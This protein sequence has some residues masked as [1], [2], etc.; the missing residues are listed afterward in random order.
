[1]ISSFIYILGRSRVSNFNQVSPSV[2][3]G[4]LPAT[5]LFNGR[6]I[7]KNGSNVNNVKE[8][9]TYATF[10]RLEIDGDLHAYT[11]NDTR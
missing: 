5:V 1:M 3:C 9:I 2:P 10:L 8:K 4:G 11:V 7:K 6:D